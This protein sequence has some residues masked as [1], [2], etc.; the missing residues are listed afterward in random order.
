MFVN[1]VGRKI[2]HSEFFA[3]QVRE[4]MA[5][6]VPFQKSIEMVLILLLRESLCCKKTWEEPDTIPNLK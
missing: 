3:I 6:G 5:S 2:P 1:V 4:K